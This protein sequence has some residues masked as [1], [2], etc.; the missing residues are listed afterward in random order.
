MSV[1]NYGLAGI[2]ALFCGIDR[3]AFGQF[4]ISRPIVAAPLAGWILGQ[5]LT[6]LQIGSMLELL[7]I[8]RLPVGAAIPPDDTQVA[9]GATAIAVIMGESLGL[10]G[11]AFSFLCLLVA[12]PLGKIGQLLDH[13]ARQWNRGLLVEAREAIAE[14]NPSRIEL[15]HWRGWS[16]FALSALACYL[17]I[18]VIGS[19]VIQLVAPYLWGPTIAATSWLWL[20][21]PLL[22]SAVLLTTINVRR[23]SFLFCMSFTTALLLLGLL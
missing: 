12:M 11:L 7:W 8:G 22:G 10:S 15:L 20:A 16:H 6:G 4:M 18:V 19:I 21:F 1:V 14:G 17:T 9:V 2:V 23:S 13:G 3:T 5:P